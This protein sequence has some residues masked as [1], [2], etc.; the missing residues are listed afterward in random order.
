MEFDQIEH[1]MMI[2]NNFEQSYTFFD[3]KGNIRYLWGIVR[4]ITTQK[5]AE[6]DS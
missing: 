1:N 2:W 3:E 4:D 6:E 5:Q